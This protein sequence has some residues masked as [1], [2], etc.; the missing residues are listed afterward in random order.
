MKSEKSEKKKIKCKTLKIQIVRKVR[1][2]LEVDVIRKNE[3]SFPSMEGL[4]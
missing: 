1:F 2:S 3:K 4:V